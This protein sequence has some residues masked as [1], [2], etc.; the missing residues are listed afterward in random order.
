MWTT[1]SC[2]EET[3]LSDRIRPFI[4]CVQTVPVQKYEFPAI[5]YLPAFI[6][7]KSHSHLQTADV[8]NSHHRRVKLILKIIYSPLF[9]QARLRRL[10]SSSTLEWGRRWVSFAHFNLLKVEVN[11]LMTRFNE[12]TM[13]WGYRAWLH[14]TNR[15]HVGPHSA[16]VPSKRSMLWV[17]ML[18][19]LLQT[20][21]TEVQL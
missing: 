12:W 9:T 6:Y 7:L 4:A 21:L 20:V 2:C 17:S 8:I 5:V 1:P 11:T 16:V 18:A 19:A 10:S 3:L 14:N 15:Q 13:L